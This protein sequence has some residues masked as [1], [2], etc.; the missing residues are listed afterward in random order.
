MSDLELDKKDST[1]DKLDGGFAVVDRERLIEQETREVTPWYKHFIHVFTAPQKMMEECFYA[2]PPKGASV[3]VVGCILFISI[4]MMLCF[5]NPEYKQMLFEQFRMQGVPEAS[6][7]TTLQIGMISG[8]IGAVISV[9]ITCFFGALVVFITKA[10]LRDKGR[11]GAFY[12]TMLLATM[13]MYGI[14][15]VDAL[16]GLV[17]GRYTTIFSLA[18]ILGVNMLSTTSLSVIATT[19]SLE[20]IAMLAIMT[21]GYK[22]ITHSSYKKAIIAIVIYEVI[23][24]A[25]SLGIMALTASLMQGLMGV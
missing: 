8:I 24:L 11:F 15:C 13:V 23:S 16:I 4:Y 14:Y 20:N 18:P 7:D 9:F 6:L 21:I 19:I 17:L 1:Q 25:F 22:V 10:I 3:G 2:D 12:K 5:V